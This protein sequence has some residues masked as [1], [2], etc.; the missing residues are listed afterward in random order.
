MT[1]LAG[2]VVRQRYKE[3]ASWILALLAALLMHGAAVLAALWRPV[4]EPVMPPSA[5][6]V[7]VSIAMLAAP[8]SEPS[9]L[10]PGPQQVES[11]AAPPPP[12][13]PTKPE[14]VQE[15][16][17][18]VTPEV[19]L[20]EV[21]EPVE[22]AREEDD[23][24]VEEVADAEQ[25]QFSESSADQSA[26]ETTAPV[27]LPVEGEVAAA[28]A[29]GAL[30]KRAADA[31]VN[32]QNILQAHLAQRKRYPR[33]AQMRRQEGV[34]WVSFTIDREGRVLDVS[35]FRASGVKSLDKETVALVHRAD[36]LPAPPPE[37]PGNTVSL[38]VPVEFF[39]GR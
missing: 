17:P 26:P 21:V 8:S 15:V 13:T 3:P 25:K 9:E 6:P 38:T 32:W 19:V 31:R 5:A 27:S 36:P 1:L 11:A 39:I 18:D 22:P 12:P 7:V 4:H 28:P 35:L 30:S 10:P 24:E 33:R 23:V 20:E 34:P 14:P 37:V 29:V 2:P 16:V